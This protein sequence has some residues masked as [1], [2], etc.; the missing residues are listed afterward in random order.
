MNPSMDNAKICLWSI[1]KN[2]VVKEVGYGY[3]HM[4]SFCFSPD[5]A[6][7]AISREPPRNIELWSTS[8]GELVKEIQ[9][10]NGG[11]QICALRFSPDG[12]Y[13]AWGHRSYWLEKSVNIINPIKLLSVDTGE[14]IKAFGGKIERVDY[15]DF[16]P[17]G[18]SIIAAGK[19]ILKY[20]E[21]D[22]CLIKFWSVE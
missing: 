20:D 13:I 7:I 17:D 9:I 16:T 5:G 21:S 10:Q 3:Q 12:K 4:Y 22:E 8:T 6:I 1:E 11:T 15:I 19:N 14:Q 2:K 18:K